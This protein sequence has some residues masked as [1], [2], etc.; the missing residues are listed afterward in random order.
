MHAGS[1]LTT[2]H[3]GSHR[4]TYHPICNDWLI[5]GMEPRNP[6][7]R[8]LVKTSQSCR[9]WTRLINPFLFVY[10]EVPQSL[11][12]SSPFQ[13]LYEL[14]VRGPGTILREIWIKEVNIPKVKTTNGYIITELH[15]RLEDS[16]KLAQEE[17][18]TV[19]RSITTRRLNLDIWKWETKC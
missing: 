16:L 6:C 7:L 9:L 4:T 19:I 14:S 17:L 18:R 8:G 2:Q 10:I 3:K 5:D 11:Q 15:E 13:L 1:I 12:E